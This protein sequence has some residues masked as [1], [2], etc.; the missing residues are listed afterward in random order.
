MMNRRVRWRKRG[1]VNQH[2][3]RHVDVLMQ[4]LGLEHGN[5]VGKNVVIK[6]EVGLLKCVWC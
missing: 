2:H 5:S 1:V 3:P 6:A 4:D